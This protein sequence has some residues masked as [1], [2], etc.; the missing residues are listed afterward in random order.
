MNTKTTETVRIAVCAALITVTAWITVPSPVPFTL[1]TFAVL[2]SCGL[3]GGKRATVAVLTYTV[4]GA[5]GLPVFS[6]FTGGIS[7]LFGATGGYIIGFSV[8]TLFMWCAERFASRSVAAL[9]LSMACALILCY[10]VGV[11]WYAFIYAS[12]ENSVGAV[13]TATVLPFVIPDVFKLA[14]A[15]TLTKRLKKHLT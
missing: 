15:V 6:G 3:I 8:M 12:G 13:I 10:V 2:L 5:V 14:L 4:L 11:L 1:Q 7:V 9:T